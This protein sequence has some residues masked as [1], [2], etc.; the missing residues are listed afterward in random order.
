MELDSFSLE[1]MTYDVRNGV[2]HVRFDRPEGANA[3][4]PAFSRDLR[5]VLLAIE[6]D[7][8]VRAASF[9]AE[10]KV[11]CGGGDLKLFHSLGAE[12][13]QVAG[14]MLVDFHGA[15]YKMN[16][17]PKPCVAGV[18]GAAGGAGLSSPPSPRNASRNS[19]ARERSAA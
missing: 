8:D 14:D 10:G 1:T 19:A 6:F 9:T 3:V 5:N 15:I 16:R 13:P 18:R 7:D 17:V 12:L 2:A 11:F 4:N